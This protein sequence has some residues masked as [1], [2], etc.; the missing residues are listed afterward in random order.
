MNKIFANM[1]MK[2]S[3]KPF[4]VIADAPGGSKGQ[5]NVPQSPISDV[6]FD[7]GDVLLR[8]DYR[9]CLEGHFPESLVSELCNA[10]N[11][12]GADDSLGFFEAESRMDCGEPSVSVIKEY[13]K[14][15]GSNLAQAFRYYIDHYEDSI[16]G[17]IDGMEALLV[18]LNNAGYGVWGLT[19]WSQETFHVVFEKFPQ[20]EPLL[21]GTVVS[22]I[23]KMHKPNADI[24]NLALNRF[25]LNAAQTVFFDDTQANVD[26]A[27]AIGINGIRFNNATQARDE[28]QRLGVK[29]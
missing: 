27:K 1:K 16:S 22:G 6:I 7:Y 17:I 15:Y 10:R 21:Q 20:L 14:N 2:A 24:F 29:I 8:L 19:N 11:T 4:R 26:G 28:L 5:A 9:P 23:E 12:N 3:P 25:N 13:K 18:D